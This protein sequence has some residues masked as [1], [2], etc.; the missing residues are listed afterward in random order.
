MS[1]DTLLKLADIALSLG[2]LGVM[3]LGFIRGDLLSRKSLEEVIGKTVS[4]VLKE[5]NV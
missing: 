4:A 2:I 5:L 1:E 3:L